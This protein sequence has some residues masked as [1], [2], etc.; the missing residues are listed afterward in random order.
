MEE[1]YRVTLSPS[2]AG[3]ASKWPEQDQAIFT[4]LVRAL[5]EAGFDVLVGAYHLLHPNVV[6]IWIEPAEIPDMLWADIDL[7]LSLGSVL[8]R[9]EVHAGMRLRLSG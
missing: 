4:G 9:I 6:V 7:R 2:L 1:R 8:L 3:R 5:S